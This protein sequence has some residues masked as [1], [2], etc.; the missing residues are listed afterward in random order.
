VS[1]A[2]FRFDGGL[3]EHLLVGWILLLNDKATRV[4]SGNE[5]DPQ[6]HVTH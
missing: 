6:Q 3:L 2:E 4:D 5:S 1:M